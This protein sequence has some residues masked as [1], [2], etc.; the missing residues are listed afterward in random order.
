LKIIEIRYTEKIYGLRDTSV[1]WFK[2]LPWS[3]AINSTSD[4]VVFQAFELV[5]DEGVNG[6][7]PIYDGILPE[8]L[9]E[10]ILG[11]NPLNVE[12]LWSKMFWAMQGRSMR[13]IGVIDAALWDIIGKVAQQPVYRLL[14]G[15]RDK[16]PAYT[17]GG[18]TNLTLE[19][20][21]EEQTWF[22]EHGSQALKMK[23]GFHSPDDDLQRV[24]AVR[25]AIGSD[26][27]LMVDANNGW[28]VNVAIRMAK[29]L[30]RYDIRW[31][32]EPVWKM[33]VEGYARVAAVTDIPI[34]TG[35][36]MSSLVYFKRMLA[37]K[38]CDIVQANPIYC[39][40]P[41][42]WRKIAALAE[43][44]GALMAPH[45]VEEHSVNAQ[46]CAAVPNGL[47]S[48][49]FVPGN[50]VPYFEFYKG[51][52]K[53]ENGWIEVSKKPGFGVEL[54]TER[55][56]WYKKNYPAGPP[57]YISMTRKPKHPGVHMKSVL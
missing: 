32:E 57:T 7:S 49:N 39:G 28:S 14:G 2:K 31:L 15:F 30:E 16:V 45:H 9:S 19:Q 18:G 37:N 20:L 33:D 34:A 48:E 56:K 4:R 46:M 25:D 50:P 47:I 11:E 6:L 41:T 27:D 42:A 12:R 8:R 5:T 17:C 54:D 21:V 13:A 52:P 35:E 22:V 36:G 10:V 38:C 40:G 23:V 55:M 29:R 44:Y 1:P 53:I 3:D 51:T 26:I 24:K 43:A